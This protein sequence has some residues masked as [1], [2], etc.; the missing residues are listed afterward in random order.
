MSP[1]LV[2]DIGGT[3]ARFCVVSG[4]DHGQYRLDQY[5]Q[6]HTGD[7]P[8]F[9]ACLQAYLQQ[10][11]GPRPRRAC[12]ALAGPVLE[13]QVHM[14]NAEWGF[15]QA[16]IKQQ[17]GFDEFI[18]INDFAALAYSVPH[19]HAEDLCTIV[20]GGGRTVRPDAPRAVIGPGTGLGVAALLRA[21]QQWLAL[22]GE[23]G[24]VAYAAQTP[25]ELAVA[26]HLQQQ[27]YLCTEAL[28]SG[29]GLVTLFNTLAELDNQPRRADSA[30]EIATWAWQQQDPLA[31]EA[32]ELFFEGLGTVAGDVAL[33]YAA[34]GGVYLGGGILPRYVEELRRSGFARRFKAKGLQSPMMADIPVFLIVHPYPA[35]IGAAAFLNSDGETP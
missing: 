6:Y 1:C 11:D 34:T 5:Q 31:L 15:S 17:F 3:S 25:R 23:G 2:A 9:E 16:A 20:E 14:T 13:D 4:R 33:L 22:P 27:G 28:I 30:R 35:L 18:A 29:P 8:S 19:L 12:V 24:F 26:G 32:C 21:R 7:F 10:L